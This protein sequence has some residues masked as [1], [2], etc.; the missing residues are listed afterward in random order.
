MNALELLKEN[1]NIV[2]LDIDKIK[3]LDFYKIPSKQE[4]A[5][6]QKKN[7]EITIEIIPK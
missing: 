3:V 7:D 4:K 2:T 5:I 6:I 1:K